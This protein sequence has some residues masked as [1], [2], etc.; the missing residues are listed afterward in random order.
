[1]SRLAYAIAVRFITWRYARWCGML[2]AIFWL[3]VFKVSQH[4]AKL[5]EFVYVNF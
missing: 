2:I 4:S 3:L 5:P 1:M